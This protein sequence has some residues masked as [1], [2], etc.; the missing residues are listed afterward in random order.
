MHRHHPV[1]LRRLTPLRV[2]AASVTFLS[3]LASSGPARSVLILD[4][5]FEPANPDIVYEFNPLKRAQTFTVGVTGQLVGFEVLID[6]RGAS[7]LEPF[8]ILPTVDGVPVYGADPLASALIRYNGDLDFFAA[9]I[10]AFDLQV[11]EGDVLALVDWGD[12]PE[13]SPQGPGWAGR[14][15]PPL[16][17]GGDLYSTTFDDPEVFVWQNGTD[18][19]FRTWVDSTAQPIPEP[20]GLALLGLGL[21]AGAVALKRRRFCYV[22]QLRAATALSIGIRLPRSSSSW[23]RKSTMRG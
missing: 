20:G 13:T 8:R 12:D 6:P 17:P 15:T 1:R 21:A 2:L 11:T 19:G 7:G 14:T 5:A 10:T 18:L 3:C 23:K 22:N 9:D 4:Q 16:Y